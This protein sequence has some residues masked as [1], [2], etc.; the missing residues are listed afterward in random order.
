M[1]VKCASVQSCVV[2]MPRIDLWAMETHIQITKNTHSCLANLQSHEM[3]KSSFK[4]SQVVMKENMLNTEK[5]KSAEM[6]KGQESKRPSHAWMSFIEQ[7]E[8][9]GVS[10]SLMILV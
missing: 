2:F 8:S 4:P 3:E 9:I 5:N 6:A 10:P 7:V 1:A